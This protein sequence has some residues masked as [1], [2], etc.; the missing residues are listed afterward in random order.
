MHSL[1]LGNLHRDRDLSNFTRH[2]IATRL[3]MRKRRKAA[4]GQLAVRL[5]FY[6][7]MSLRGLNPFGWVTEGKK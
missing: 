6:V 5:A 3:R 4:F 1:A 2:C 7:H